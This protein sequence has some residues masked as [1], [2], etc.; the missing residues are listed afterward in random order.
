VNA[1]MA[2]LHQ[3]AG[4]MGLDLDE[5]VKKVSPVAVKTIAE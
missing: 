3:V 2:A 1:S 5:F 4:A